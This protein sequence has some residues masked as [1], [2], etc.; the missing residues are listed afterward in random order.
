MEQGHHRAF[1]PFR[2]DGPQG[3]L[4]QGDQRIALRPQSLAL[5]RYAVGLQAALM[6]RCTLADLEREY[7]LLALEWA[8]GKKT[9]AADLLRIDRKTLYRKLVEY[10]KEV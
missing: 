10:G 9:E 2:L 3:R 1:G 8:E 5:L 7:I 4:W 6:R